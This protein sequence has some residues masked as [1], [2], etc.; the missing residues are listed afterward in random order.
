MA[1]QVTKAQ[2][3]REQRYREQ[4]KRCGFRSW[5]SAN[6]R[7]GSLIDAGD[8]ADK[9]ELK[10]LQIL[11]DRYLEWKSDGYRARRQAINAAIRKIRNQM[12]SIVEK[13]RGLHG[14]TS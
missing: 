7:R 5:K 13:A 6:A 2:Q 12:D 1:R 3:R 11:A 4:L 8:D 9:E 10:Q 14:R